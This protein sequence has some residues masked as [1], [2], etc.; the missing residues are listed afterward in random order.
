MKT[1]FIRVLETDD[2][3]A[4]LR[5]AVRNPE[6][7]AGS[8]FDID[9]TSFAAVPRSPFAYWVSSTVRQLFRECP[10]FEAEGRRALGGLKTLSDERFVRTWWEIPPSESASWP[11]LAK[12][13]AFSPFYADVYLCVNWK[14]EGEEIS[15]YGYQRRPREGFGAA[16]RGID[17]YFHAGLTWPRR[18]NGLSVR[19]MPAGCIFADKGPA[20]FVENDDP[21]ELLAL[22]ALTNSAAFGLLVSLQ[23][24]RTELAQ[25]YEV[26]LIQNTPIPR[27]NK[28]EQS[29][30]AEL[31]KNAWGLYREIDTCREI[32]H[33]FNLPALLQVK[34]KDVAT[35]VRGW[36]DRLQEI[37]RELRK[38]GSDIDNR[39]FD[40]YGL[41]ED[42]RNTIGS[43]LETPGNSSGD[44]EGVLGNQEQDETGDE[45]G[46][47]RTDSDPVSLAASLVSWAVGAAFGRFDVR[48]ATGEASL[49]PSFGP[50][51]ALP[52]CSPAMLVSDNG[53]PLTS[54]PTGYPLTFPRSGV[55]VDDHGNTRDITAGVRSV[56]EVLFTSELDGWWNDLGRI[57][58]PRA[59]NLASWI[60]TD[61][62]EFHL[63]QYSKS[64]RKAPIIWQLSVPSG[65]YSI[66]LYA[67]ALARDSFLQLQT[68][69]VA[70]KL[71]YEER[72]LEALRHSNDGNER[73]QLSEQQTLVDE[74]R[75]LLDEVKLVAPLWKPELEDGAVIVMAPLW[76]LF[77]QQRQW[78]LELKTKW[79]E[80]VRGDYDWT[81]LAMYL[82]PD[83]VVPKCAADRS[84]AIAHGLDEVFWFEDS[85]GKWKHCDKPKKAI[86]SL[87]S[88]RTSPGVKAALKGFLE[89]PDRTSS[90]RRSRR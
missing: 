40:L 41:S 85:D 86:S 20:A 83:R 70:P 67:H 34:G 43:V 37:D 89:A 56:F 23:L 53:L 4:A 51:D 1:V 14:T 46:S 19:A 88:E 76:R 77:P 6:L 64:R 15:W 38:I 2:K 90:P 78:Q 49:A 26:G 75:E 79:N 80:L 7:S 59:G 48:L 16:S 62:F 52:I 18:T 60:A 71:A 8:R 31:A 61:Y 36:E 5:A 54:P 28:K 58:D 66:W 3:A 63:K 81:S 73:R 27:W 10:R 74:L 35:R 87:I 82:W 13:G 32:S 11:G 50:F 65:R 39:C 69:V 24:A 21:I 25:S 33:A 45:D 42:D 9:V 72:Q 55:L 30:L 12:G 68:D 84:L 17:A 44:E 22:A 47:T 57:L 29:A